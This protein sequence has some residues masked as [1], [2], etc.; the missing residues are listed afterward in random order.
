MAARTRRPP[1]RVTII[2][3][4]ERVLQTFEMVFQR[5]GHGCC[6]VTNDTVADAAIVDLDGP[7]ARALWRDYAARHPDHPILLVC[8][9]EESP[10]AGIELLRKPVKID[11]LLAAME[12]IRARIEGGEPTKTRGVDRGV[13]RSVTATRVLR[14]GGPAVEAVPEAPTMTLKLPV[15]PPGLQPAPAEAAPEPRTDYSA[16]CGAYED[17]DPDETDAVRRLVLPVGGR[18]LGVLRGALRAAVEAGGRRL[19]ELPQ[20][21]LLVDAATAR[22]RCPLAEATLRSLCAAES[23]EP[24]PA[25]RKLVDAEPP[26]AGSGEPIS[27]LLWRLALWTY[28]GRL[29]EDTDIHSRVFLRHWPNLTRLLETPDAMRIAALWSE[30]PMS[31]PHTAEALRVPQRHVFAFYAAA[32]TIGLAGQARRES[33]YLLSAG[34]G[35]ADPQRPALGRLLARLGAAVRGR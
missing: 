11:T 16:V 19:V 20:G 3:A 8:A 7:D 14:Q 9:G 21:A 12:R 25:P 10:P 17:I 2:G 18:F 27:A 33:D 4:S 34:P 26:P 29:P 23:F 35:E 30:Q 6:L 15:P 22:V 24:V 31:L 13:D 32:H 1:I 28:R 5:A